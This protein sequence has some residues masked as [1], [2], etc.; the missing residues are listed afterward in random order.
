MKRFRKFILGGIA[1]VAIGGFAMFNV[2]LN[3][4]N[5]VYKACSSGGTDHNVPKIKHYF[6][7]KG[8]L[9][10]KISFLFIN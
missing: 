9:Q 6:I 8:N 4:Q 5:G 10:S 2:S 3:S 7:Q 1:A